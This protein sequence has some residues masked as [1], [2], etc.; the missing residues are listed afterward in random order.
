MF[1]L[2]IYGSVTGESIGKLFIAGIVPG[3]ILN[4][5]IYGFAS[6]QTRHI[7]DTPATWG[8]ERMGSY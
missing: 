1:P 6:Y 4:Y 5:T 7:K 8:K 3:L 2:I